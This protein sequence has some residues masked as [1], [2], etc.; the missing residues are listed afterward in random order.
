M[1]QKPSQFSTTKL[2]LHRHARTAFTQARTLT[3]QTCHAS[4]VSQL[5]GAC[6][7][8]KTIKCD[9]TLVGENHRMHHLFSLCVQPPCM[10]AYT[11]KQVSFLGHVG[12]NRILERKWPSS[13]P[14]NA[15]CAELS[16]H[17]PSE[18]AAKTRVMVWCCVLY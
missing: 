18:W 14:Y 7:L 12:A 1:V 9:G 17:M 11:L 16:A 6:N 10:H 8:V 5:A 3:T 13:H 4:S 2:E 15:M